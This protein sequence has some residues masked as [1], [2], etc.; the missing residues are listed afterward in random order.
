MDLPVPDLP[1]TVVDRLHRTIHSSGGRYAEWR[2]GARRAQG[3]GGQAVFAERVDPVTARLVVD[4]LRRLGA[5]DDGVA[6]PEA[7][8]VFAYRPEAWR[9]RSKAAVA[10]GA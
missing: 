6:D 9:H 3:P 4:H 7:N 2:V 5:Q 10:P 8:E 1:E